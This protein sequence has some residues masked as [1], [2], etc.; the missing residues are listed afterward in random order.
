MYVIKNKW[1]RRKTLHRNHLFLVGQA[2][3][4]L[5]MAKLFQTMFT[6]MLP[7]TPHQE[8]NAEYQPLME[9]E[10]DV[11]AQHTSGWR[12]L[13]TCQMQSIACQMQ[14]EL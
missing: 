4:A 1:G 7:E 6:V 13:E 9:L 2:D 11:N 10:P 12:F 14:L 5:V 8:A 3:T